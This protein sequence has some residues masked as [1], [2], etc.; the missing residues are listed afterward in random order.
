MPRPK[1]K[2]GQEVIKASA[3]I[4]IE[5]QIT[6]LQRRAWNVLLAHAY[7]ELP[8]KERHSI[9][10]PE[11]IRDLEYD[12][13]NQEYLKESLKALIHSSVEW[14][15]LGK[16]GK[17]RWGAAALIAGVEIN[18]GV[19]VYEY[20]SV[21]REKLYNPQMYARLSLLVQ[22]RFESKHALTL[23]ELCVDY[24]GAKREYGE[25]PWIDVDDLRKILGVE[26]SHYYGATFKHL[27]QK[28]LTPAVTAITQLSDFTVTVAYQHQG[29]KVMALKFS[30]ER[31]AMRPALAPPAAL[32]A[33]VP[34]ADAV[35]PVVQALT[36][37]GL[38]SKEAQTIAQRGWDFVQGAH[39][40]EVTDPDPDAAFGRYVQEKIHLLQRRV[41]AGV[42]TNRT[43]F[44]R[45]ALQQHYA[46][47]EFAAE[48]AARAALAQRQ[49]QA[50]RTTRR[51]HLKRQIEDVQQAWNTALGTALLTLA[52][53]L[54]QV[55]EDAVTSTLEAT[56]FLRNLCAVE[57]SPLD[58]YRASYVLRNVVNPKL[59][60]YAPEQVQ[61][62]EAQYAPQLAALQAQM[63]EVSRTP[64]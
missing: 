46:N 38:S 32:A 56:P 37:A 24:L 58:H 39:R 57:G 52:D 10:V 34:P 53:T 44:L 59:A 27:K 21:L 28:I 64:A 7:H 11:L 45:K 17:N 19:C 51:A 4:Q 1:K 29:R 16:D 41:E 55:V 5:G 8:Y 61:A 25:T 23:W 54:P 35:S 49:T 9:L 6:L 20:A 33:V 47:P 12:S 40:P 22:N 60:P 48:E 30:M 63:E 2:T 13:G 26:N 50:E 62:L 15:I 18:D 31:K 36:A 42:V 43:G 3:A 14:N